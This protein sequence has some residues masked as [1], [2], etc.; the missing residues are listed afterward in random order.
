MFSIGVL[1]CIQFGLFTKLPLRSFANSIAALNS[2]VK[3]NS[4]EYQFRSS[5]L[6]EY[7]CPKF[8][9]KILDFSMTFILINTFLRM[10]S[11][12]FQYFSRYYRIDNFHN[13]KQ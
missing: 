12:I 3:T 5:I 8:F 2:V 7:D 11:F 6:T 9:G 1:L 4:I 13:P 10:T